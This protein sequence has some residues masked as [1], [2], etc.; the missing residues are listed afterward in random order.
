MNDAEEP[1]RL[2]AEA[3]ALMGVGRHEQ[4]LAALGRASALDPDA[5]G[6][7]L[8][9]AQSL[10]ALKRDGE[11]LDAASAAA[12]RDPESSHAQRLIALAQLR[13]GSD[14]AARDAALQAV[15]L[16]PD[17]SLNYVVLGEALQATRDEAGALV[18]ARHAIE[19]APESFPGHELEGRLR[20]EHEDESGAEAAFRRALAIDPENEA[21]LNNL[22]L[23]LEKQGRR[24][25]AVAALE[26]AARIDPADATVR[27]NVIRIGRRRLA[28]VRALG[29]GLVVF[30]LLTGVAGVADG[31]VASLVAGAVLVLIGAVGIDWSIRSAH[32]GLSGPS[33]QLVRDD[34]RAR[35][36]KPWRWNWSWIPRLRPWWWLLLQRIPPPAALLVNVVVGIALPILLVGVP[37]SAWR[38]WRWYRRLHPGARSWRPPA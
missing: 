32:R 22:A 26:A 21:I 14:K 31:D 34:H 17:E 30:G 18:A 36:Y 23:A 38:A 25:E 13:G 16:D 19:L 15:A 5:P 27:G 29:A 35:R 24:G 1:W 20:L 37:F 6:P 8:L 4:A 12:T 11:A 28:W 10:L 3:R 9:R 7:H 2:I 33:A